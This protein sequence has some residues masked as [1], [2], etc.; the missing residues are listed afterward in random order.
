M[1]NGAICATITMIVLKLT[2]HLDDVTWWAI[3]A[4]VWVVAILW[5]A[6]NFSVGFV[7][8]VV[9]RMQNPPVITTARRR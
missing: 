4:P 9:K 7:R 8:E 1:I 6:V 2:G 3:T 5:V